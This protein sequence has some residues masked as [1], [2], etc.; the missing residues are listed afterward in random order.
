MVTAMVLSVTCL[1][2]AQAGWSVRY[3]SSCSV[4]VLGQTNRLISGAYT[5]TYDILP[6]Q[7][8]SEAGLVGW[9][10]SCLE[11]FNQS[12][13]YCYTPPTSG[14][15]FTD[16]RATAI[17]IANYSGQLQT[18]HKHYYG[19]QP[20]GLTPVAD[21]VKSTT[22]PQH[23]C[24]PNITCSGTPILVPTRKALDKEKL[25][26]E[27]RISGTEK[28]VAFDL[29]GD[30]TPEIVGWP[31]KDDVAFLAI[32][33][34]QNGYIDNGKELFGDANGNPNGFAELLARAQ[35]IQVTAGS[36][37]ATHPLFSKL[38]LWTDANRDGF[39]QPDEL[40]PASNRLS[41]IGLGWETLTG[42]VADQNGNL[43]RVR[44]WAEFIDPE[45]PNARIDKG[46]YVT[47]VHPLWDVILIK[48]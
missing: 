3:S 38:L 37:D 28:G 9:S 41:K 1:A 13:S 47:N 12:G 32:D 26:R 15:G 8:K 20:P 23:Y 6:I 25:K 31:E 45:N 22:C 4:E 33:D 18:W 46:D 24:P 7:V 48:K 36:L 17:R 19:T 43:F 11:G 10:V 21:Y 34:N 27:Y 14:T 35:A 5:G 39:S 29:N 16:A 40:E 2:S 30:G 42:D 44:G